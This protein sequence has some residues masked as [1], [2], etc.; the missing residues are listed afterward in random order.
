MGAATTLVS[1]ITPAYNAE[2]YLPETIASVLAQSLTNFEL[3]IVDDKSTDG[4][5]GL[6]RAF[7]CRD[8]RI[9]VIASP[10]N[11]GQPTA[12][13]FAMRQA[14]GQFFALLDSDDVWQPSYL[15][16]QMSVFEQ[17]G[18]AAVVTANA[19]NRGGPL[20]GRPLWPVT[21][22]LRRLTLR[23]ILSAED[24][25]CIM[26]MFRR[27]VFETIGGFDS[28]WRAS[29]DYHF[30]VRAAHAGFV[31]IRNARPLAFY[32]RRPDSES[33]NDRRMLRGII[34]MFKEIEQL[35]ADRPV[36]RAEVRRQIAAFRRRL[37]IADIRAWL[38][39]WG[40]LDLLSQAPGG[41]LARR[42][43]GPR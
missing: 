1:I 3:L 9:K 36:E 35:C 6:A 27:Q 26:S 19:I 15:Q 10:E 39:H 17:I 22:G 5:L 25:V 29:E 8:A 11:Q 20:D 24:S 4:T 30:W 33:S 38:R 28:R 21:S 40:V 14:R 16:E 12:R 32:R 18:D 23:D 31:V 7:A 37:I 13:N 41:R 43:A 34:P 42:L 2:A